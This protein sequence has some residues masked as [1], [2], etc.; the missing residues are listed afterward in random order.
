[1]CT[2][3][4][5]QW[6]CSAHANGWG[7]GPLDFRHIPEFKIRPEYPVKSEIPRILLGKLQA[8]QIDLL[9]VALRHINL[10]SGS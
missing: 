9:Q 6:Q 7:G 10:I 5:V 8:V 3:C 2:I 1:M 4:T